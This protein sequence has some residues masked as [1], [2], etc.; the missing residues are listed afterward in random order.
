MIFN[1]YVYIPHYYDIY[2]YM[3]MY[4]VCSYIKETYINGI[5]GNII[6]ANDM[7]TSCRGCGAEKW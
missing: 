1:V 7:V 6:W 2:I 3:Y 4:I 5:F